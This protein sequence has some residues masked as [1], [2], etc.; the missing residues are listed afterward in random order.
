M[1]GDASVLSGWPS[2]V[3]YPSDTEIA[4]TSRIPIG[5]AG[6]AVLWL[7]AGHCAHGKAVSLLTCL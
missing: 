3:A 7:L 2:L 1:L 6:L 5:L 4:V